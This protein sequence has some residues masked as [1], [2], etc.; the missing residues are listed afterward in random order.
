MCMRCG[1][2]SRKKYCP[3]CRIANQVEGIDRS[4]KKDFVSY[5]KRNPVYFAGLARHGGQTPDELFEEIREGGRLNVTGYLH[6]VSS[7]E[8]RR[9][10]AKAGTGHIAQSLPRVQK[11]APGGERRVHPETERALR[12]AEAALR[13]IWS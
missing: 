2:E 10:E 13:D 6:M 5:M 11:A 1:K 3:P 9:G 4:K 7:G 8:A 12:G